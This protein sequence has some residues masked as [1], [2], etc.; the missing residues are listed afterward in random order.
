[1][2]ATIVSMHSPD[3]ESLEDYVPPEQAFCVFLQLLIGPKGASGEESFNLQV[4]SPEWLKQQ[5]LP[6]VGRHLLI[7]S[8]FDLREIH[9]FL[10]GAIDL[11]E[12]DTWLEVAKKVARIGKWEFEDYQ[13]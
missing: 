2:K 5:V 4:C 10:Q 7:V 13:N 12:A 8:R 11:I 3:V 9:D 1:M 6:M